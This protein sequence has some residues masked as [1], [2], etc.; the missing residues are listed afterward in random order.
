MGGVKKGETQPPN[1]VLNDTGEAT[2]KILIREMVPTRTNNVEKPKEGGRSLSHLRRGRR[3]LGEHA[4]DRLWISS[5][6]TSVPR[7]IPI[8]KKEKGHSFLLPGDGRG[9]AHERKVKT[10]GDSG[11]A[12]KG[13]EMAYTNSLWDSYWQERGELADAMNYMFKNRRPGESVP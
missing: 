1:C 3:A 6:G 5:V 7:K 10:M 2:H 9:K 4:L 13:G 12:R 8:L 11:R